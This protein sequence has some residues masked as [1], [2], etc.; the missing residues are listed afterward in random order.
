M[1]A[2]SYGKERINTDYAL[3]NPGIYYIKA[4]LYN[5]LSGNTV[6]SEP[7]SII[8]EEPQGDDLETWNKIKEDGK[9]GL[10]IQTGGLIEHPKGRKTIEVINN[11]EKI[12][13]LH[14]NSRY[15]DSIRFALSKHQKAIEQIEKKE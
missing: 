2:K 5:P 1:Y 13:S 11:L 12:L 8:V 15:A 3:T 9:Y 7:V 14:Q 6:E 4:A 10:F